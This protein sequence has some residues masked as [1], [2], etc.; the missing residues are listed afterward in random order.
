MQRAKGRE[1][2]RGSMAR[3]DEWVAGALALAML[4]C[5]GLALAQPAEPGPDPSRP[6]SEDAELV[7]CRLPAEINR[8]GR[9]LTILGARQKIETSRP[10]CLARGGE[11]I[12]ARTPSAEPTDQPR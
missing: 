7:A 1:L 9:Q 11:V 10:D 2:R 12:D 8:L 6:A 3:R 5:A 4:G